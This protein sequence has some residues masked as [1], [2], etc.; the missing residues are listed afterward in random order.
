ML[1]SLNPIKP[2]PKGGEGVQGAIAKPPGRL[3]RGETPAGKQPPPTST[4]C[5]SEY[6]IIV[7]E[8]AL[9][10]LSYSLQSVLSVVFLAYFCI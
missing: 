7:D 9:L 8:T 5:R 10:V 1:P 4:P 6:N 3:R 2:I